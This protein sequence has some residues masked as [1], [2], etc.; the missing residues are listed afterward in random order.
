[1]YSR[2]MRVLAT[3][4]PAPITSSVAVVS[5]TSPSYLPR[6]RRALPLCLV[7]G[8]E[9]RIETVAAARL[10]YPGGANQH[11]I[12]ARD[13]PLRVVRRIAAHHANRQRLGD[14]LG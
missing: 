2:S 9:G 10:V 11:T 8:G 7:G 3:R 5:S 13:Q 14:V 4:K 1:M 12:A 6:P